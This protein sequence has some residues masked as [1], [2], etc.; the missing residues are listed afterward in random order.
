MKRPFDI[1]EVIELIL[2]GKSNHDI[3]NFYQQPY[4]TFRNFINNEAHSAR[5][6]EAKQDAA[7]SYSDLAEK[8]IREAEKDPIEMTRARELASHYRWKASKYAPKKFGD[9]VSLEHTG[10]DGGAIKTQNIDLTKLSDS[11]LSILSKAISDS[12]SGNS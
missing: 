4:T 5:V 2:S 8:V 10:A 7:E 6:R 9:K 1:E 11:E 12:T 3:A